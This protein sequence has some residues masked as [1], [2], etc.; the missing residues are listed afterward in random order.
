MSPGPAAVHSWMMT[1]D[2]TLLQHQHHHHHQ[3]QQQQHFQHLQQLQHL[4]HQSIPDDPDRMLGAAMSWEMLCKTTLGHVDPD[5]NPD[6]PG[7]DL[8][9]DMSSGRSSEKCVSKLSSLPSHYANQHLVHHQLSDLALV[10][11]CSKVEAARK[12]ADNLVDTDLL[13]DREHHIFKVAFKKSLS[14]QT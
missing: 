4:R 7:F 2:P 9:L 11:G 6:D 3:Q 8:F 14:H 13:E 5:P 1:T 10:T 12:E